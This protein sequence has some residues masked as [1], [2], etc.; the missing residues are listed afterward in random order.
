MTPADERIRDADRTRSIIL[1]AAAELFVEKGFAD[2]PV[3]G[4]ANKAG[5]TKSLIHHHFGSK[6]D[7]WWAVK[8]LLF[9]EYEESQARM[10]EEGEP[11]TGLL[12]KSMEMYFRFLQRNPQFV[13]FLAWTYLEQQGDIDA[14]V[15]KDLTVKGVGMIAA[16]QEAGEIRKDVDPRFI[17]F[18]F[19]GLVQNWFQLR[20]IFFGVLGEEGPI[21]DLDEAYLEGLKKIF[22]EGVLPPRKI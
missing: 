5:V 11:D 9:Q 21:E 7:L 6:E 4:I 15:P 20:K 13:R 3:S 22:F 17:L 10:L 1:K 18:T 14:C 2:T 19:L 16:G 8:E 12:K